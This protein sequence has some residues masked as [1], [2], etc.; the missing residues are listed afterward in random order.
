M[1]L[2]RRIAITVV[3][4]LAALVTVFLAVTSIVI[5]RTY[6]ASDIDNAVALVL[7]ARSGIDN[8]VKSI[9]NSCSD[10]AYWDDT[11][12][13]AN[14]AKPT[15]VASNL[16][17]ASMKNAGI[18]GMLFLDAKG[19]IL[20]GKQVNASGTVLTPIAP[21]VVQ[22]FAPGSPLFTGVMS[23]T[24]A[25]GL[26]FVGSQPATVAAR[27]ILT[28]AFA[29]PP[30]GVL[31]FTR[32]LSPS[33]VSATNPLLK[34]TLY[35]ESAAA[36]VPSSPA[37]SVLARMDQGS[38]PVG[39]LT[40]NATAAGFLTMNDITGTRDVLL[41]ITSP[42]MRLGEAAQFKRFLAVSSVL[43]GLVIL[44]VILRLVY[45]VVLSRVASLGDQVES[46]GATHDLSKR[47]SLQGRTN[48]PALRGLSM[49]PL[50]HWND[51]SRN[52]TA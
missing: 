2:R 46:V 38:H 15:Y 49:R 6:V 1:T 21:D 3:L 12:E 11:F 33:V 13:F 50:I 18:D 30:A 17:A 9:G 22:A 24:E 39:M 26:L 34:T 10:W 28:S 42:R 41:T 14:H 31:V 5:D 51:R 16:S 23:G 45:Q 52:E 48:C 35:I 47:V 29:G 44:V 25:G 20:F 37:A 40:D 7:Q 8:A 36:V 4:T 19:S 27:R 32:M 43:M